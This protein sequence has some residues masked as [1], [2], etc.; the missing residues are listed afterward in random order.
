MFPHQ[1]MQGRFLRRPPLVVDRVRR[2]RA[3]HGFALESHPD[4]NAR[5]TIARHRGSA[6]AEQGK[7]RST[8]DLARALKKRFSVAKVAVDG[9]DRL[10]SVE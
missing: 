7:L 10:T 6:G 4:A 9:L 1:S 2:R 8:A 5:T 3:Q